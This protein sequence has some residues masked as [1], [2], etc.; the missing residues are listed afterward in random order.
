VTLFAPG[1]VQSVITLEPLAPGQWGYRS[2]TGIRQVGLGGVE[3]YRA[4]YVNRA[5]AMYE[6]LTQR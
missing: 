1:D 3:R 2:V 5:V 6:H 4:S